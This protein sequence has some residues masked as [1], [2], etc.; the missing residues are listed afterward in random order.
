MKAVMVMLLLVVMAGCSEQ[1][2][3]VLDDVKSQTANRQSEVRHVNPATAAE[4]IAD[5][6]PL[7]LDVRTEEEFAVSH[8]RG[9]LR[10]EPGGAVLNRDD[11]DQLIVCYCSVGVRSATYARRLIDAGYTNVYNMNG[12]IFQWANEGRPVYRGDQR[13]EEVHP[14]DRRWGLLLKENLRADVP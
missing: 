10:V 2:P 7:L 11:K 12:S 9:A 14:F 1:P 3:V 8:L 13:V 4:W 5:R 6:S